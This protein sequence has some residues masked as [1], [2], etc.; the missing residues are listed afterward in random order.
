[1]DTNANAPKLPKATQ[2]EL[3]A[4]AAEIFATVA[5]HCQLHADRLHEDPEQILRL[6]V[7]KAQGG[8]PKRQA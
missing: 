4:A 2:G 8:L 1:V 5:A 7:Q 6:V 3:N